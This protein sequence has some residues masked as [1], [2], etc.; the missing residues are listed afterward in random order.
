M[1]MRAYGI[2]PDTAPADNFA[3]AGDTYYTNYLS[4]A[5][6]LGITN[7]IGD[8]LYAPDAMISR[9]DMFTLLYRALELLGELPAA[10][11]GSST[12][13]FSDADGIAAYALTAMETFLAADIVHGS[14][15]LLD[16]AGTS[17]R[18]Q[19]AQVLCNLLS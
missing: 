10:T 5:K 13:D 19:M 16:A 9:Q 12:A 3:D 18:A 7:G 14:D 6:R 17:T 1:L 15:G 2:D 8:N 11:T 4:A